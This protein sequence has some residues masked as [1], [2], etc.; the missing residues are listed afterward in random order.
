MTL[1]ACLE[2]EVILDYCTLYESIKPL[3]AYFQ[4]LTHLAQKPATHQTLFN[5]SRFQQLYHLTLKVIEVSKNFTNILICFDACTGLESP[6]TVLLSTEQQVSKRK[7]HSIRHA[8]N[9]AESANYFGHIVK[10]RILITTQIS[11][12]HFALFIPRTAINIAYRLLFGKKIE[13][14]ISVLGKGGNGEI[15][16]VKL[17]DEI[18][19]KKTVRS[20][21]E[22]NKKLCIIAI[23]TIAIASSKLLEFYHKRPTTVYS[24]SGLFDCYKALHEH[25]KLFLTSLIDFVEDMLIGLA[26]LHTENIGLFS[27]EDKTRFK[28]FGKFSN[29]QVHVDFKSQNCVIFEGKNRRSVKLVDMDTMKR[30][31]ELI[32]KIYCTYRNISPD[33]ASAYLGVENSRAVTIYDDSWALGCTLYEIVF[34]I[35]LFSDHPKKS[36]IKLLQE[37][38][39][40]SQACIDAKIKPLFQLKC[41]N[42]WEKTLSKQYSNI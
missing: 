36:L 38:A 33:A 17:M 34:G 28:A 37:I 9:G 21:K 42:S 35:S 22:T 41:F 6:N 14:V 15:V 18:C 11:N 7:I 13:E 25:K 2:K 3:D 20:N 19:A 26:K 24:E 40:T 12:P 1:T 39:T 4:I 31:R 8:I 27:L 23:K 30:D 16:Q 10:Q 32:S 5:V 29:G